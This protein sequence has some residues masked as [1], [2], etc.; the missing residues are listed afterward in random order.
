MGGLAL[1]G[2]IA[3]LTLYVMRGKQVEATAKLARA[4]VRNGKVEEARKLVDHWSA[5]APN[6]GEPD[7]YRAW[8]ETKETHP[9][10]ALEAMKAADAKGYP[11]EKLLALRAV[12]MARAAK[13]K[14]ALPALQDSFMDDT[15]PVAEIADGLVRCY[16]QGLQLAETSAV[17]D[18]WRQY[19]PDDPRLYI[20]QV[21]V[22]K[23]LG[24]DEEV[25]VRNYL[26]A[27]RLDPSLDRIRLE[28]AEKFLKNSRIE[29]ASKEF[30]ILLAH[31]PNSAPPTLVRDG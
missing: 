26:Q 17:L 16:L 11:E 1:T 2:A 12:L 23:R 10:E 6:D 8:L 18:R 25:V 22:D 3:F 28:V 5:M 31:Q 30:D 27:L 15:G 13:Y 20:W 24:V 4:A 19:A 7:Y 14:D 29:E 21:E 9:I